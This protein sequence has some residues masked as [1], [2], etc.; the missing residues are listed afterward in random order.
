MISGWFRNRTATYNREEQIL[1]FH[2]GTR[3]SPDCM[4]GVCFYFEVPL[5]TLQSNYLG[6]MLGGDS[7]EIGRLFREMK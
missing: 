4:E 5:Q 3:D 6:K 1:V 7:G 2:F